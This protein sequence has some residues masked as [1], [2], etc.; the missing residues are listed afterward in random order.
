M[1]G[2]NYLLP[3][4]YCTKTYQINL[5]AIAKTL[6]YLACRRLIIVGIG[7]L[8][9]V[10]S[11]ARLLSTNTMLLLSYLGTVWCLVF[12]VP[13]TIAL[14]VFTPYSYPDDIADVCCFP[15]SV[16]T[17][18]VWLSVAFCSLS[19]CAVVHYIKSC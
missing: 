10:P 14:F 4:E 1:Q 16:E 11:G 13:T 19:K 5:D 6:E 8:I 3:S 17:N 7:P 15:F 12:L 2:L 9:L 18:Q